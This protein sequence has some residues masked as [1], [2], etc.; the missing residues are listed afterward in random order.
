MPFFYF[1][2]HMSEIPENSKEENLNKLILLL[3]VSQISDFEGIDGGL[4][5]EATNGE[6]DVVRIDVVGGFALQKV[7]EDRSYFRY[8]VVT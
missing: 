4:K 8:V 5:S 1:G 7:T 2:F 6:K 3:I